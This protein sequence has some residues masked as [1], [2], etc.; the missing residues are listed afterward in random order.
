MHGKLRWVN[1]ARQCLYELTNGLHQNELSWSQSTPRAGILCSSSS[2]KP[3]RQRQQTHTPKDIKRMQMYNSVNN[4][5]NDYLPTLSSRE[6]AH[7]ARVHH[8]GDTHIICINKAYMIACCA[9]L[10]CTRTAFMPFLVYQTVCMCVPIPGHDEINSAALERY[11]LRQSGANVMRQQGER[12][13]PT[14]RCI[15][16]IQFALNYSSMMQMWARFQRRLDHRTS[17]FAMGTIQGSHRQLC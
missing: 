10:M 17:I 15:V 2:Q 4:V 11:V 5:N 6:G 16:S 13:Q 7:V 1:Y 3:A 12:W 9:G 8:S 14:V